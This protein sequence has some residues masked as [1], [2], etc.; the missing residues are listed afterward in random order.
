MTRASLRGKVQTVR[1]PI[2]PDT[3]GPTLMHEHLLCDLVP[4]RYNTDDGLESEITLETTFEIN[5]GR[6]PH[7]GKF[8]LDH[9]DCAIGFMLFLNM[10]I[11]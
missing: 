8:R 5:Y 9:L 1:G 7:R 2:E 4:P 6:V 10:V 11:C 3:L